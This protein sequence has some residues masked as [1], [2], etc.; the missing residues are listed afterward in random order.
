MINSGVL[1]RMMKL[2]LLV[3]SML[4]AMA[5]PASSQEDSCKTIHRIAADAVP[6]TIFHTNEFLRGGE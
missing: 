1:E 4:A 3:I 2:S 5:L 6:S